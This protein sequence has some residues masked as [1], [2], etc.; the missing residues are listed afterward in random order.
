MSTTKG[1]TCFSAKIKHGHVKV[2]AE[3]S[4]IRDIVVN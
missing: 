3:I 4:E 1:T 2:S